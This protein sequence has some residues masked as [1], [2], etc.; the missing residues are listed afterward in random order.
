MKWTRRRMVQ[1]LLAA[2]AGAAAIPIRAVSQ[3][4][5]AGGF[6]PAERETL[7]AACERV[8]PGAREAGTVA[9]IEYW[10][11]REPFFATG[12]EFRLG[13][14]HLDRLARQRQGKSY[15]SLPEPEQDDIL[16]HLQGGGVQAK[17]FDGAGFFVRLLSFTVEAIFCDPRYGGNPGVGMALLGRRGCLWNPVPGIAGTRGDLPEE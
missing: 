6:D 5:A 7:G 12:R 9:Y 4:H 2:G 11:R 8:F 15:S 13:A 3:D 17:G 16:R 14:R 1:S 10:T